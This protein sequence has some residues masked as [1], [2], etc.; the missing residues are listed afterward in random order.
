VYVVAPK[1]QKK[2][3]KNKKKKLSLSRLSLCVWG[4]EIEKENL[5]KTVLVYYNNNNISI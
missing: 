1:E 3:S 5:K 2:F 4:Y